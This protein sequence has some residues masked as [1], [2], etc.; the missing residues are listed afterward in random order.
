MDAAVQSKPVGNVQALIWLSL[1]AALVALLGGSARFDAVQIAALR[2]LA[3][4]FLIPAFY[5]LSRDS[6]KDAKV[7]LLLLAA[8]TVWTAIQLIPL[9]PALWHALPGRG[10]LAEL[11]AMHGLEGTWRPIAWVPMRGWNALMAL[12][13][14]IAAALL[15]IALRPSGQSVLLIIAAMGCADAAL[16]LLQIT[17]GAGSPLY[18]YTH[19]NGGAP[20]GIFANENHSAVF[21]AMVLVVIARLGFSPRKRRVNPV[22]FIALAAAYILVLISLLVS[23]SRAGLGIGLVG[24][25]ATAVLAYLWLAKPKPGISA[26]KPMAL[27]MQ[28]PRTVMLAGLGAFLALLFALFQFERVPGLIDAMDQSAFEDLRWRI[29][30]IL[31]EMMAAYWV[32]GIGFGSFD[33][34]YM[35]EEPT[36]LLNSAY[37]NQAHND[38]AQIVIEG[39]IPAVLI[40]IALGVWTYL[41]VRSLY[42]Q[43]FAALGRCVFWVTIAAMLTVASLFDYPLR[44]PIIQTIGV[45]L[46]L[47]LAFDVRD[48]TAKAAKEMK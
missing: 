34:V 33:A 42:A 23:G 46:A 4:L 30:P 35:I 28:R 19:T 38:W 3:A 11:D 39:G 16:G 45:W 15:V 1:F 32:F 37:L 27:M 9:P 13:I 31:Q 12:V 41:A 6:A 21:S 26:P 17:A 2:P 47:V 25:I 43:N 14:P 29:L 40:V 5:Y 20:V 36:E 10:L 7:P 22:Y 48:N 44:T 18:T 24:V 8:I